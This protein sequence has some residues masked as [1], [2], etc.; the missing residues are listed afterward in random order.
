[1]TSRPDINKALAHHSLGVSISASEDT[2]GLGLDT[3]EVNRAVL[4]I[5]EA[6]LGQGARVVFGHDWR[7]DGVMETV[8]TLAMGY[9]RRTADDHAAAPMTNFLAWPDRTSLSPERRKHYEGMLEV[10][11]FDRPALPNGV[12]MAPGKAADLVLRVTALTE[13]RKV[14]ADACTARVCFGGPTFGSQGLCAGIFEEAALTVE[15]DKPLYVTS[16][17][18]GAG[19]QVVRAVTGRPLTRPATTPTPEIVEALEGVGLPS[20]ASRY[21]TI[22]NAKGLEGISTDNGLSP[23]QN[24]QL[25]AAQSL[26]EVIGWVLRG[27]SKV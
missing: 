18:G 17:F 16:L 4:Q 14:M 20:D 22:L 3:H 5:S 6:A 9:H 1:M 11:E 25:F 21:E 8:L 15:R 13:M 27:L 24:L 7:P 10:V 2:D 12:T 19:A 23:D 26:S